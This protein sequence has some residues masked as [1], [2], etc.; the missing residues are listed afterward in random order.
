MNEAT[1]SS[2]EP[3]DG[4]A[5]AALARDDLRAMAALLA[6]NHPGPANDADP[7]FMDRLESRLAEALREAERVR[8]LS[9]LHRTLRRYAVG[10]RDGHVSYRPLADAVARHWPG[11]LVRLDEDGAFRVSVSEVADAPPEA[12]LMALDGTPPGEVLAAEV[13]PFRWNAAIPHTRADHAPRL[14]IPDPDRPRPK[15]CT[16]EIEGRTQDLILAW[17]TAEAVDVEA[18]VRAAIGRVVPRFGVR[19]VDGVAFV[20]MPT[21]EHDHVP[22][23]FYD[24]LAAAVP[25]LHAAPWV[26]LDVRGNGGGSTE[27]GSRTLGLL[28]GEAAVRRVADS[29]DWTVDWRASSGNIA[30]LRRQA[31]ADISDP[32]IDLLEKACAAGETLARA[33]ATVTEPEGE[34]PPSPFAGRVFLLTDGAC[35]SACLDFADIARR[36]PGVVHV[37]RPTN[38]DTLYIEV[39]GEMLPSGLGQ[40]AVPMK[41]YR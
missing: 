21:M 17:Q 25:G 32:P 2:F 23:A 27:I 41:V 3:A 6:E 14:L 11:F 39:R 31:E 29:F 19:D 37:G 22:E 7:G 16:L 20:S 38:A 33:T 35:A 5:F 15:R 40:I 24:E 12:V 8:S 28:F 30:E 1:T 10:F 26:V 34:A 13:L 4:S 18:R 9:A 36:L